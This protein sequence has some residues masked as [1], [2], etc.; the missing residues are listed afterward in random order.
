MM[1]MVDWWQIVGPLFAVQVI[2]AAF[3]RY[4]NRSCC[5]LGVRSWM[6]LSQTI[7]WFSLLC[8]SLRADVLNSPPIACFLCDWM[9]A[10]IRLKIFICVIGI[11]SLSYGKV[12]G[13]KK[14]PSVYKIADAIYMWVIWAIRLKSIF[15]SLDCGNIRTKYF[16]ILKQKT[17]IDR[18]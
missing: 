10:L 16:L 8:W 15:G 12:Q 1:I 3:Y 7:V 14:S 17:L 9:K 4:D 6:T 2:C 18:K 11:K 5:S 13:R